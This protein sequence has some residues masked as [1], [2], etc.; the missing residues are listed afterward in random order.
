MR[1]WLT[2]A[3]V[4]GI[5]VCC[6]SALHAQETRWV[7]HCDRDGR[8]W[9]VRV[10][11]LPRGDALR[12]IADFRDYGV[13]A[14]HMRVTR[15]GNDVVLRGILR[16][17][18]VTF[19]GRMTDE[20][21]SG[22]FTA[23][24]RNF[25]DRR[26]E[27]EFTLHRSRSSKPDVVTEEIRFHNGDVE[28]AGTLIKPVGAGP[29]PAIVWTHGSGPQ[30]RKTISYAGRAHLVAQHGIAALIYDKRGVGDSGGDWRSTTLRQLAEDSA[31]AVRALAKRPD[32]NAKQ[33]GVGGMSQGGWISPLAASIE[34]DVAFVLV[35]SAAG[36][37]PQEQ[38][39]FSIENLLRRRGVPADQVSRVMA[40]R[41][42]YDH[43]WRTGKDRQKVE[44][45]LLAARKEFDN[46]P[47]FQDAALP[48]PPLEP[49]DAVWKR[50]YMLVEPASV[51]GEVKTP[52]LA[53]WG[54]LDAHVPAQKS[55]EII[56]GVLQQG[57]NPDVTLKIFPNAGHGI[58]LF[59]GED[60]P[61]DWP[62]LAPGYHELIVEWLTARV[63]IAHRQ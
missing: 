35:G 19:R 42:S 30:T 52:V 37:T 18:L 33:I 61:W 57:G 23:R 32:I 44:Q 5:A 16:D 7:G 39:N 20:S 31:F 10:R 26:V 28:L 50:D 46:E 11:I 45:R 53:M 56:G 63:D 36:I 25:R 49:G 2:Y 17:S 13:Y 15:D 51:W 48:L 6:V 55:R 4:L 60:A 40:V 8:L 21:I 59:Q 29:H 38:N 27:A 58:S 22:T 43:F 41:R 62:R 12:A 24:G 1:A 9:N 3:T 34:S 14:R 47:W 54:E